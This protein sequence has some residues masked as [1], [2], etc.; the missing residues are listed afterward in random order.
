MLNL[1]IDGWS[2]RPMEMGDADALQSILSQYEVAKYLMPIK[3]PFPEGAAEAWLKDKLKNPSAQ[4]TSFA[5]LNPE[6]EVCG[7]VGFDEDENNAHLGYYLDIPYWGDGVMTNAVWT[8]CNWLFD[9]TNIDLIRSGVFAFN[10]ASLTIQ[11]RHG[12]VETGRGT[13]FC[14]A[15]ASEFP[16]IDTE[17]TRDIFCKKRDGFHA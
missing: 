8:V 7:N 10:T 3:H 13:A 14:A 1:Q 11:K 15:Q 12:F 17:L 6:G 16:H 9:N 2:L 5:I 4:N